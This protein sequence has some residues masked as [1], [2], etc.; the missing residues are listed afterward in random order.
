MRNAAA[1]P[2]QGRGASSGETRA[3]RFGGRS[4]DGLLDRVLGL[5][6]EAPPAPP[7]LDGDLHRAHAAAANPN[8]QMP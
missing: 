5:F 6:E 1:G 4:L 7:V 2:P 3:A 8:P